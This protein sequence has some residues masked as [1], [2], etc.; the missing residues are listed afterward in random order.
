MNSPLFCIND[1]T[2][3]AKQNREEINKKRDNYKYHKHLSNNIVPF[4]KRTTKQFKKRI[5]KQL[6]NNDL[7]LQLKYFHLLLNHR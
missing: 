1:V 6:S 7:Y 4:K 3:E 2:T 5:T